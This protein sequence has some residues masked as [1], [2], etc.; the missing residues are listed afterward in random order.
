MAELVS[1][2]QLAAGRMLAG[3]TQAELAAA[4]CLHVNSV[5]YVERQ[6]RVTTGHSC[7]VIER[8]MRGFGVVFF[9]APTPGVRL[10]GDDE[11]GTRIVLTSDNF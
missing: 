10:A 6:P 9:R 3:V 2:K 4:A 7:Q 11:F 8:A 1:G 5:R